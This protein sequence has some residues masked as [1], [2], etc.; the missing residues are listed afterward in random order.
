MADGIGPC[1][2]EDAGHRLRAVLHHQ[3]TDEDVEALLRGAATAA[4]LLQ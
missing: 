4:A 1:H 2:F 3:V